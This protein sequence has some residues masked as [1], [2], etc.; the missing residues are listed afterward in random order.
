VLSTN[1]ID[2]RVDAAWDIASDHRTVLRAHYGRYHDALLTAHF[3]FF[4]F[5]DA[6]P[7]VTAREVAPN[8]FVELSR[9]PPATNY[10]LDPAIASAYFDQYVV[11]IERELR[12]HWALTAQIV[13]RNY[14]NLV[15]TVDTGTVYE[16]VPRTDPG[17]DGRLG[18][19]DDGGAIT[20]YRNTNAAPAFY[21]L[22][23]PPN[24]YRRYSALQLIARKQHAN[25]WQMQASYTWSSTRGNVENSARSNSGGPETGFNGI[26]ANPNRAINADGP[27]LFDFTH[28]IKVLATWRLSAFG[29]MTVSGVYQ[30]HTG[31]AWTRTAFPQGIPVTFGIR[32]EPR[33]SRRT[34]AL[35]Q[36]DAR[37][38][39][40]VDVGKGRRVGIL[41]DVFNVTNQ[42]IPD[43]SKR[44]AVEFRSGATF[45]QPLN[46]VAPRT[47]RAGLRLMF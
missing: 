19:A 9:T 3:G 27:A 47:L 44:S 35:N 33:G 1:P 14:Q 32:M 40:T 15:G 30:Y 8:Q 2:P 10:G 38:E 26:F 20:A 23:N 34:D 12:P 13:R 29:G 4:N 39:K 28:E 6:P 21:Y 36:L 31:L 25:N 18:T 43:P 24:A 17:P 22:T 16:P 5:A 45:G 11:G 37:V 46:W 42:G 41:A 7:I